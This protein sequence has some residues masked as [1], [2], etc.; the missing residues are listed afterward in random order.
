MRFVAILGQLCEI[1]TSHNI[2]SPVLI[3]SGTL[4][5]QTESQGKQ[6]TVQVSGVLSYSGIA[7]TYLVVRLISQALCVA[8]WFKFE[9]KK[10]Q[11]FDV[12]QWFLKI[13]SSRFACDNRKQ[14]SYR[15]NRPLKPYDNRS[16]RQFDIVEIVYDFSMT[17]VARATKIACD[18]RIVVS[19]IMIIAS[20]V[21]SEIPIQGL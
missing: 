4:P 21:S 19:S 16:D 18:N 13:S 5:T 1:A 7:V 20:S 6:K 14:K 10:E 12:K 3:Y 15:V 11:N 17:R 2:R 9:N 8:A